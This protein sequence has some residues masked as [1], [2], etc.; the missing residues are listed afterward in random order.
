M[1]KLENEIYGSNERFNIESKKESINTVDIIFEKN[2]NFEE[3]L[4]LG[5]KIQQDYNTT[6]DR[7]VDKINVNERLRTTANHKK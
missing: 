2:T 3:I 1:N 4:E 7:K 5:T 6:E